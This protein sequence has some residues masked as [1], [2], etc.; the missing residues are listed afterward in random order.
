MHTV[1]LGALLLLGYQ[2]PTASNSLQQCRVH[3]VAL[4]QAMV[5]VHYGMPYFEANYFRAEQKLFPNSNDVVQGGCIVGTLTQEL[6]AYCEQCRTA[7]Q[8]WVT[9]YKLR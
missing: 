7:R 3:H 9:R 1:I 5:P 8:Q 2:H 6:V 4:K